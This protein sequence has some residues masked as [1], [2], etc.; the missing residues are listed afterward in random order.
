MH[1]SHRGAPRAQAH[2]L[3]TRYARPCKDVFNA[4]HF[5]VSYISRAY[6][7]RFIHKLVA[8][9]AHHILLLRSPRTTLTP[10]SSRKYLEMSLNMSRSSKTVRNC[11]EMASEEKVPPAGLGTLACAGADKRCS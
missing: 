10:F 4:A 8:V 1:P 3:L 2:A 7:H 5:M 9:A 6:C 11:H